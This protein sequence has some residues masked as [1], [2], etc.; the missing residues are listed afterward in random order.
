MFKQAKSLLMVTGT[1]QGNSG[2]S[3][4]MPDIACSSFKFFSFFFFFFLFLKDTFC[5]KIMLHSLWV[6]CSAIESDSCKARN[7]EVILIGVFP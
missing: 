2:L 4:I 6:E 3:I 1:I 5:P 7:M